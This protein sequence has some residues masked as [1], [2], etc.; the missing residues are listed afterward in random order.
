MVPY[1]RFDSR[2]RGN[3][4]GGDLVFP[5]R[6]PALRKLLVSMISEGHPSSNGTCIV[7][8]STRL[9]AIL[10]NGEQNVTS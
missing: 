8:L 6:T 5:K 4:K 1:S 10:A 2:E 3:G 9:S 7:Y